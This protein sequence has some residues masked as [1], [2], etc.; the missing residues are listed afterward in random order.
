MVCA[1]LACEFGKTPLM[2]AM[3]IMLTSM[4]DTAAPAIR[5]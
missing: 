5:G 3:P 2:A 1:A 4:T